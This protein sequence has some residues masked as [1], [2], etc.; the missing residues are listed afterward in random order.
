MSASSV[1]GLSASVEILN[2]FMGGTGGAQTEIAQTISLHC[3]VTH[4]PGKIEYNC[5][6]FLMTFRKQIRKK[7]WSKWFP[8]STGYYVSLPIEQFLKFKN[9]CSLVQISS[10]AVTGRKKSRCK[11]F[12]VKNIWSDHTELVRQ[13]NKLLKLVH[14]RV[15]CYLADC[16]HTT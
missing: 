11:R 7:I 8:Y 14:Q 15:K 10:Y 6:Y 16:E 9:P 4:S 3:G 13:I 2:S 1:V 5:R 12:S